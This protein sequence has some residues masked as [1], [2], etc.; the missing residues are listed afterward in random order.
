MGEHGLHIHSIG[1]VDNECR[2]T[3]RDWNPYGSQHGPPNSPRPFTHRHYGDLG[4]V[5]ANSEGVASINFTDSVIKL[6]GI[7]GDTLWW[8]LKYRTLRASFLII[9]FFWFH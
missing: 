6:T 8:T 3:G 9:L 5:A 1:S 7:S 2:D 4:N